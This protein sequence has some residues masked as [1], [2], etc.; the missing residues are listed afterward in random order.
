MSAYALA[1]PHSVPKVSAETHGVPNGDAAAL[2]V[3]IDLRSDTVTKPS[4]SVRSERLPSLRAHT[5][6]VALAAAPRQ[7]SP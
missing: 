3:R 1:Q 2:P 5:G 7:R 6:A 4:P